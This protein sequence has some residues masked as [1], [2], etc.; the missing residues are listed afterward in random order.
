[1]YRPISAFLETSF[2]STTSRGGVSVRAPRLRAQE[3]VRA[4][5]TWSRIGSTLPAA[6]D[7]LLSASL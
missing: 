7:D 3:T 6:A 1:M 4:W 5:R 2:I